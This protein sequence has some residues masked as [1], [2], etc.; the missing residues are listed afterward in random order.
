MLYRNISKEMFLFSLV[1]SFFFVDFCVFCWLSIKGLEE[2]GY[3]VG[4]CGQLFQKWAKSDV[5]GLYI[6]KFMVSCFKVVGSLFGVVGR[7]WYVLFQNLYI[8][9][10]HHLKLYQYL[11]SWHYTFQQILFFLIF[12]QKSHLCTNL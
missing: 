1:L 4:M 9:S 12:L 5:L 7:Y 11:S 6:I 3:L 2:K 8:F 10:F